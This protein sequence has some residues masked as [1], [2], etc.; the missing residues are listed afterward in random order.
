[1]HILSHTYTML[2]SYDIMSGPGSSLLLLELPLG[3]RLAHQNM[4]EKPE[5]RNKMTSHN[6][7]HTIAPPYNKH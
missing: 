3:A 6:Q 5:T 2:V 1:V 4:H 7:A